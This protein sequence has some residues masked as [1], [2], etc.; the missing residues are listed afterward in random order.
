MDMHSLSAALAAGTSSPPV[1]GSSKAWAIVGG[2]AFLVFLYVVTA[3]ITRHWRAS[4]LF[5]GFDGFG[6]TSKLQWFLWLLAVFFAY[7]A[8]WV[9]RAQQDHYDPLTQIPVN[10]LTVLGFSTG[11][12]AAAKGI[13]VGLVQSGKVTKSGAPTGAPPRNTG[14]IFQDDGGAPELAKIQMIG[15]TIIAIGI[16]LTIVIHQVVAGDLT[17]GLPNIDSSLMVLMGISQGGYLGKKLVTFGAPALYPLSPENGIPGTS[18]TARGSN[19]GSAADS[20]LLLNGVVINA[21]WTAASVQ[22]AV[23]EN[24]P[25]TGAPWTGLPN[26]VPVI[27]SVS[28]QP[29]NSVNFTILK[30]VL[31]PPN[32]AIGLPGSS[33]TLPGANLGSQPG[34][35][36][37]FAGAPLDATSWTATSI[38]FT[39]PVD[40]PA[41]GAPWARL[42]RDMAVRVRAGGQ[43]SDPVTFKVTPAPP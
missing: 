11:T 32:P 12:A 13:T 43:V 27:V 34:S 23:P 5:R 31:N 26:P 42:P 38:Q 24:D 22:F 36:L 10:L 6:S 33:V 3:L 1:P 25:A 2:V 8:I 28:G 15:F 18:V 39:V 19:L 4:E 41:T 20:Q 37:E 9:L 40:D 16:F 14:G 29:S 35:Q 30:P 7:V 21:S 17:H